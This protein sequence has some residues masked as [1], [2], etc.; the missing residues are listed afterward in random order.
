MLPLCFCGEGN[1]EDRSLLQKGKGEPARATAL[2]QLAQST[3][4]PLTAPTEDQ[5]LL[6]SMGR[7]GESE[8]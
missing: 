3:L 8:P 5:S 1:A 4:W 2:A 6:D 7:G